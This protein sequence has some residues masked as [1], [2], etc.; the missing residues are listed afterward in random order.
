MKMEFVG[1]PYD[2]QVFDVDPASASMIY[3][4]L[5]C[6]YVHLFSCRR[7]PGKSGF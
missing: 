1:G 6:K 4:P 2:G 7:L 5:P 3:A